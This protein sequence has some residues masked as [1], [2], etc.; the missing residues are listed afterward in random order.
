MEINYLIT[1]VD[2]FLNG[3]KLT[4]KNDL[5]IFQMNKKYDEIFED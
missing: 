4:M 3:N 1:N 5:L 2:N